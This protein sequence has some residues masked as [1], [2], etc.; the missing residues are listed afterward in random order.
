MKDMFE[1][2]KEFAK[3]TYGYDVVRSDKGVSLTDI[4][5][6][7]KTSELMREYVG[8]STIVKEYSYVSENSLSQM[9]AFSI[10]DEFIEA[11]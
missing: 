11:A 2:F 8:Y 10:S 5:D 7:M 3:E 9:E 4:F 1:K 6:D